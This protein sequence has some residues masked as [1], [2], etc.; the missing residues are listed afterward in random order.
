MKKIRLLLVALALI[1][2][3]TSFAGGIM[4]NTNQSAAWVRMLCRD[5]VI[6]IDGVYFN[7]AGLTQ[8][9]EGIFLSVNN[10]SLV[11]NRVITSD[12]TYLNSSEFKGVVNAPLFPSVY[13]AYN[14]GKLSISLGFNAIGG[15]GGAT[16]DKGLPSLEY[17]QSELLP[18]FN[19]LNTAVGTPAGVDLSA[20]A[21][22]MDAFFEGT[23]IY[24]GMQ[25]GATYQIN[26]MI[27]IFLGG[28]YVIA[29][30]TYNGHLKDVMIDNP[31]Q[32]SVRADD[33]INTT[34]LPTVNGTV[35]NLNDVIA[36]P[37]TLTPALPLIGGLTIAQ[38]VG[39]GA[40]T[41]EQ[42]DGIAAGTSLVG[43]DPDTYTLQQITDLITGATPTLQAQVAQLQGTATELGGAAVLL[44]DQE[45]DVEQTGSGFTPIVGVNLNFEDKLNIGIKYE[46][47]TKIELENATAKRCNYGL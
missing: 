11:Q 13:A 9:G 5:A 30:N 7:P 38:A 25:V 39:A 37:T 32:G 23:S 21:Y 3:K 16:F 44:A 33:F 6:G 41:A 12:Y 20:T 10:Q 29:K 18:K 8:M 43:G 22:S 24:W 42:G 14:T 31:T 27:S 34:I 36:I 47:A 46:M 15:G 17:A 2:L 35:D 4:T 19:A 40:L 26:D 45:A 28:R 1:M